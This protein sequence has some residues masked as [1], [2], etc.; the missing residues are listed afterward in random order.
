M[1]LEIL[2]DAS[3]VQLT[4]TFRGFFGELAKADLQNLS[5]NKIQAN[6]TAYKLMIARTFSSLLRKG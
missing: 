1:N 6:L 4:Q 2:T 3:L 5:T